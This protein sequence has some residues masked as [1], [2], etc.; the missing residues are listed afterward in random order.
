MFFPSQQPSSQEP[1][2][3]QIQHLRYRVNKSFLV[4]TEGKKSYDE[5]LKMKAKM[6]IVINEE[7]DG[8]N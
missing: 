7:L 4:S 8:E 2:P 6:K 3:V 5:E 1:A